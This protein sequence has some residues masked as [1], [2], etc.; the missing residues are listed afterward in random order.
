MRIKNFIGEV[1][2]MK[3][4]VWDIRVVQ[5]VTLRV[6]FEEEVSEDEAIDGVYNENYY[7]VIDERDHKTLEV[8]SAE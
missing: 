2:D 6:C 7:D 5:E 8:L 4:D 1:I 3:Q